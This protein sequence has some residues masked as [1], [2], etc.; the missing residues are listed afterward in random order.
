[1]KYFY[2]ITFSVFIS[3]FSFAQ[4]ASDALVLD[5]G[6]ED[7]NDDSPTG[8]S[9]TN[10]G[11]TLTEDRFGNTN[12]ALSFD[13]IDDYLEIPAN[14]AYQMEDFPFSVA[15]TFKPEQTNNDP[16]GLF[17]NGSEAASYG[18]LL[19]NFTYEEDSYTLSTAIGDGQGVGPADRN[20]LRVSDVSAD[21]H[22][23]VIVYNALGDYD[24]YLDCVQSEST[25]P[26]G[27][28]ASLGYPSPKPVGVVGVNHTSTIEPNYFFKGVIDELQVW[29]KAL[30]ESEITA[31]CDITALNPVYNPAGVTV[32]PNPTTG[33]ISFEEEM[34]QVIVTEITGQA[35]ITE[36]TTQTLDL[37]SLEAGTYIV[38]YETTSGLKGN[39]KVVKQ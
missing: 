12:Q 3:T 7:N 39:T 27:S 29:D 36:T 14:D 34:N 33:I 21:W 28:G 22:Q 35:L 11:A 26:S 19:I 32:F 6:F 10:N 9:F 16:A 38:T 2:T 18:G 1:M 31:Y 37:S 25:T 8:L 13:G 15:I 24:I 5:F 17:Y 30:T 4:I 23:V 20:G